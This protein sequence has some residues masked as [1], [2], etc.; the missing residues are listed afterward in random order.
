MAS[1][2]TFLNLFSQMFKCL[3]FLLR[4]CVFIECFSYESNYKKK[5]K[6]SFSN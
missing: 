2:H 6:T 3:Q 4:H 1:L 5:E